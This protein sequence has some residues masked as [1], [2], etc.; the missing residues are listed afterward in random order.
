MNIQKEEEGRIRAE[1]ESQYRAQR[2][3]SQEDDDLALALQKQEEENIRKQR[4]DVSL[5]DEAVARRLA[6]EEN[7]GNPDLHEDLP[8]SS[9]PLGHGILD[10]NE[11]ALTDSA[12]SRALS[13]GLFGDNKDEVMAHSPDH[14]PLPF[15]PIPSSLPPISSSLTQS[16]QS[17][18]W[19]EAVENRY[20]TAQQM[21][22]ERQTVLDEEIARKLEVTRSCE[23]V[24]PSVFSF[25]VCFD[26]QFRME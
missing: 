21:K 10:D 20:F 9:P 2:I 17:R 5:S 19:K 24:Q 22:L 15:S 3:I 4:D 16:T 1:R 11:A 13:A 14:H 25:L 6:E 8:P 18:Q 26:N 7:A 23:V 12:V